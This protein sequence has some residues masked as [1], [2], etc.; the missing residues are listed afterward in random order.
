MS[1]ALYGGPI[2]QPDIVTE[3]Q[4][5]TGMDG[6]GGH[7]VPVHGMGDTV[8]AAVKEL[9]QFRVRGRQKRFPTH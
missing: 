7:T 4:P 5:S 2:S 8:P 1:H 6:P 9:S 3:K